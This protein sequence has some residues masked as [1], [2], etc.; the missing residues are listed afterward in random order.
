LTTINKI[1]GKKDIAGLYIHVPFCKSR[2]NY[3][4]FYSQTNLNLIEGFVNAARK[5]IKLLS[6]NWQKQ[7]FASIYFGGGN[8]ACLSIE[9]ISM[10]ISELKKN[11]NI[12]NDAEITIEINPEG[13]NSDY[14]VNLKHLGFNRISIG[15]QSFS[16]RLLKNL[17]RRHSASDA[18]NVIETI[19][20]CGI[21]NI[22]LDLMFG[23]P[24]LS[25]KLWEETLKKTFHTNISHLSAYL[26][27]L[28]EGTVLYRKVISNIMSLPDDEIVCEQY[29]ILCEIS[30]KYG[31]E[32]YEISNFGKPN[33]KS[34]HNR[35]YWYG[36]PYIGIGPSAHSYDGNN[37]RSW[38][39]RDMKKY[40]LKLEGN[41][42]PTEKEFLSKNDKIN[43]YIITRLR[44]ED[45]IDLNLL[46]KYFGADISRKLKTKL[47]N[48]AHSNIIC[49]NKNR[50]QIN[51][52][53]L[54]FS[55]KIIRDLM[56][57]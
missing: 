41:D 29:K 8:P 30:N 3:C 37:V 33:Y 14:I 42:L 38:N 5:E 57:I 45:G 32:H 13:I 46:E 43:D 22:S 31:F 40:I 35:L 49:I 9:S 56:F 27:S 52:P 24:D 54:I 53:D 44:T 50:I 2:C 48:Q 26:L 6:N 1:L 21:S 16:D 20:K 15:V 34:I 51:E 17:G 47:N 36:N 19:N 7:R 28:E 11:F 23:I 12:I 18:E 4:D 10:I 39:V 25:I 55:D